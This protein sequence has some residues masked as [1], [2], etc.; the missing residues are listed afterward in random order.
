MYFQINIA[1]NIILSVNVRN[2]D[3]FDSKASLSTKNTYLLYSLSA[4]FISGGRLD[5][6]VLL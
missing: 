4:V 2:S 5:T 6:I 1:Q 3:A